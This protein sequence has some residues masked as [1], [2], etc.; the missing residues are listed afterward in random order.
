MKDEILLVNILAWWI[1]RSLV[2]AGSV[3]LSLV[4]SSQG[5]HKQMIRAFSQESCVYTSNGPDR[6]TGSYFANPT[7]YHDL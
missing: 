1:I 4:Q 6:P 2:P 3:L 5:Q 7:D